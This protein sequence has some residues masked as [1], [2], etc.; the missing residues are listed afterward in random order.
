M[1]LLQNIG[2]DVCRAIAYGPRCFDPSSATAIGIAVLA[3]LCAFGAY[4]FL[5]S[6]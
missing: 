1:S 2:G 6:R 3:G 5:G 4:T